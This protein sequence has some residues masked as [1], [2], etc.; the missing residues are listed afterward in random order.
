MSDTDKVFAGIAIWA[1][2]SHA[3]EAKITEQVK[4]GIFPVRL[5]SEHAD[6]CDP[7]AP[8]RVSQ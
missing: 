2:V 3:V 5:S 4:A 1:S 8:H 7:Y 6:A